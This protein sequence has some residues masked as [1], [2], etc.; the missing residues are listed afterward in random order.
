MLSNR[1]MQCRKCADKCMDNAK[2]IPLAELKRRA[3]LGHKAKAQI[4]IKFWAPHDLAEV[5][6][7]YA[8][9]NGA[10]ARCNNPNNDAYHHYGGRGIQFKFSSPTD[11]TKWVLDN[12]GM[13]PDAS[14]SI[15]RI[16][17]D[18]HYEPG[19][20]RWATRSEQARNKR[21]YKRSA[22][23]EAIRRILNMRADLTYECVW[24]WLKNGLSEED[25]ITRRKHATTGI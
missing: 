12:I 24:R 11:A 25:I 16:D 7:V 9:M 15:D 3:E 8:V 19:N 10:C 20:L 21:A 2:T 5:E 1:S 23:G 4:R 18:R 6:R 22:N 14:Y 17:N 13:R